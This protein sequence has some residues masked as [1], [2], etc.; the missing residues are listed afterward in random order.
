VIGGLGALVILLFV[1]G[2]LPAVLMPIAVAVAAI[3]NTFTLVWG[4]TYITDVSIIVQFLIALVGLGVAIDYALLMIFRFRDELRHGNDVESALVET[5][6]HAGRSVIVS[7]STVAIGLLAMVA[8]PLP[9]LRS[10]GLGGM[11]I[12]ASPCSPR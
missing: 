10:M 5:M 1:F 9:L 6:T 3:L 7:G 12:P 4:L 8:L 2:T 11:L